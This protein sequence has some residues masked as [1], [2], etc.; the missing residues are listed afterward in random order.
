MQAIQG[1]VVA[2]TGA[3]RGIGAATARLFAKEQAKL[4]LCGRDGKALAE[5]AGSLGL[6]KSDCHTVLADVTRASGMKNLVNAAYKK[7]GTV[8]IFINN[9]GVGVRKEIVLTSEKEYDLTFNTNVKAI[10]YSFLELIPRMKKQGGGQ[11]INISSMAGKQGVPNLSV[12]CASKAAVNVLSEAVAGE[13]RNDNIKV[14]VLMPGSTGTGFMSHLAA[15]LKPSPK[16]KPR[17]T[18][19]EVAEAVLF[20][21]KQN[22]N[23]WTSLVDIR[24]LLVKK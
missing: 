16:D 18:P 10:Y 20:I 4:V 23:A 22:Q 19:E 7:F 6:P 13:V 2:I 14:S 8:D 9:A 11:I 12:Y 3:S 24:P 17:L 5:V 1:K 15:D 21:A